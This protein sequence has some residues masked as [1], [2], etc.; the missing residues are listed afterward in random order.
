M[1]ERMTDVFISYSRN[2]A[3][4]AERFAR[5]F[6]ALG[7]SV[8]WDV[9][10]RSGET[11]DEA[12]EQA[13]RASKVVVV[14]WSRASVGSRWVRT[15]ATLADRAGK[16]A[17]V[18][19]EAC[20]RPILFELTHTADLTHWS[21]DR[22]D[23]AWQ[24]LAEDVHKIMCACVPVQPRGA[25]AAP[26]APATAKDL[27]PA[28][29]VLPF[30]NMSGDSE[31]EYFSDGVSEDIITDLNKISALS[32]ISRNTAFG[33]KGKTVAAAA[34]ARQL[35]VSH[36]LEGSVRKSGNRVRITAQLLEAHTDAQI[37]AERF[38]RTLDD[39]FAI[40][41]DISKAIV[42][43]LRLKL[44][45]EEKRAIEQRSTSSSEA[46]E[47]YVIARAFARKGSERLKP[48]IVRICQRAV[49]LDPKFAPGWA[50]MSFAESELGQRGVD[51][52]G[53]ERARASA[54]RAIDADP[55]YAPG[56]AAMAEA[57]LRGMVKD[58][59]IDDLLGRAFDL[60]PDCY[61]AHLMAGAA[62][63]AKRDYETAIHH[64]ERAIALDDDAYWP[65]GMVV[66]AYEALADEGNVEAAQ[67]RCLA[68]CEKI[69]A[70]E[71][72]HAGAI[73]FMV[74]AL[75]ALGESE[76]VYEWVK[77]GLLFD[78]GNARLHYNLA[79]GL[80]RLGD[81]EKAAELIEPW[82]DKV[83]TGWLLWMQTDSSLDPVR[84]HSRFAALMAR[85]KA[86]IDA[87]TAE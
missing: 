77:R 11:F 12:I 58:Q 57:Q 49:E 76:R 81:G 6:E 74:S 86:R 18:M 43:A 62:A 28:I 27:R 37:W 68:R 38:D 72:D 44:A 39:V 46:Y 60:D 2:D 36:I 79:C 50:M 33:Y 42:S 55:N 19:I 70:A 52:F 5:G 8:W 78:P 23:K 61:E 56:Y 35:G 17:P 24:A 15:E 69:L 9:A 65:A 45:P 14:L 40:Q 82:I 59:P 13:L 30:V 64:F 4:A 16:L 48:V 3:A 84:D 80:A 85:G 51:G 66:Q 83:S 25:V 53:F 1:L 22:A 32:V 87:N 75:A 29:L 71:P 7:Y 21:G 67:R 31:Q 63:I 34:L 54:Q 47:L 41:D 10:L 73:G 20:E 26:A